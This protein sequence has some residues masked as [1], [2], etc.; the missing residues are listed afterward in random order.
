MRGGK[1]RW[2]RRSGAIYRCPYLERGLGYRSGEAH[3]AAGASAMLG[4][5]SWPE[6]EDDT[7]AP[8]VSERREGEAVPVREREELGHGL[9][10]PLGRNVAP[11]PFVSLFL[12]LFLIS[13]SF[14]T[15]AK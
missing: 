11:R 10:L 2:G 14:R 3:R 9:F 1:E 8:H 15:F 12:F 7:R 4:R 5:V 13:I 6:E